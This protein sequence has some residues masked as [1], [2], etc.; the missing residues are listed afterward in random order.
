MRVVLPKGAARDIGLQGGIFTNDLRR[1]F[2]AIDEWEVGGLM[3]NDVSI[4]RIDNMPFGGWKDSIFGGHAIYGP[5]GVSFYTRQKVVISRWA[6]PV[7]RG[8]DLGF[9][10]HG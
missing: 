1:A 7:H 4:F 10:T 8:V 2:R 9:P 6:D 3:I 5:E